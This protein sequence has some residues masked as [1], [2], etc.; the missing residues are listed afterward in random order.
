MTAKTTNRDTLEEAIIEFVKE[1]ASRPLKIRELAKAMEVEPDDYAKFRRGIKRLLGAGTLVNI[2]RGRIGMPEQLDLLVGRISITRA[3]TGF[4]IRDEGDK[5]PQSANNESEERDLLI[6]AEMISTALDG[7]KVMV[8]REGHMRGREAGSVIK[9]LER[10][11]RKLVGVF[12][13]T[14]H[15]NIVTPDNQRIHRDIY[16]HSDNTLSAEKGQ[17]VVVELDDWTDPYRNPEGRVIE[18]LGA[19][20]S[21]KVDILAIMRSYDLTEE[22]PHEVLR[23]AEQ[24]SA[25]MSAEEIA[26]REDF[27]EAMIYTIDPADAKDHDDAIHVERLES[28]YRLGVHIADVSHFV[29]EGSLLDTEAYERGNSVYLPGKVIPMLPESLS[30]DMCSLRE[31]EDRLAFSIIIEFDS[32]GSALEWRVANTVIR[33]KAKLS[34]EDAQSVFDG[35][36][37]SDIAARFSDELLLARELSRKIFALRMADG[38][39]DFDLPESQIEL[40]ENGEV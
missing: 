4:L 24:S 9:I 33:S 7:D 20:G 11:R 15:F 22:F 1:T 19:P 25:L 30:N 36:P 8:R 13:Q 38:S 16:I 35:S 14:P 23:L 39:L 6:P 26:G 5:K 31:N 32:K 28:G 27:R 37:I 12:H 2:K 18:I 17:K 29:Q 40:D 21:A 3:G 10:A 34:Y